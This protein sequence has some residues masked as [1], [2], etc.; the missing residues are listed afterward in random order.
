MTV[1]LGY[2]CI[3]MTLQSKFG[4]TANRTCRKATFEAKGLP[5][6][7]SL[8][9][10]NLEAIY[11][12]I[13]WNVANNIFVYRMSSDIA[14]WASEY[15]FEELPNWP[16]CKALL[17][18][19]GKYARD[20]N[21]RL[22]FHP[23]QFNCMASHNPDV[24]RRSVIDLENHGRIFDLM[25]YPKNNWTKINIHIGGTYGDKSSTASR[26]VDNLSLLSGSVISRLTV[27]NDDRPSMYSTQDLYNMVFK[28]SGIPIVFDYHHHICHPGTINE[29]DALHMAASTWGDVTPTCH[30][31]ESATF[32]DRPKAPIR[33]HSKY[34]VQSINDYGLDLDI[35]IEAKC[36]ELAL[37]KYREIH[38]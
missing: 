4:I 3:N 15:K 11:S 20:K 27:E 12:I 26:F 35:V 23:G 38:G 2:A 25:G 31:A 10:E 32:H 28:K 29:Y 19:I 34:V 37:L 21:V 14:P 16:T 1:R 5:H 30:Y 36:K 18:K 24:V 33:A 17:E 6:V 8:F 13:K 9:Q 7:G 22:S